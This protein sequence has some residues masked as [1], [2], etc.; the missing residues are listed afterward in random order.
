MKCLKIA[1]KREFG[2]LKK[3]LSSSLTYYSLLENIVEKTNSLVILE[4]YY[5]LLNSNILKIFSEKF[6]MQ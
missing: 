5:L 1:Q 3:V 2:I 4:T 6:L